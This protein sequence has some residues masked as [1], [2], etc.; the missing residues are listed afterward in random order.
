MREYIEETADSDTFQELVARKYYDGQL[1][2]ETAERLVGTE[3]AQ[4]LRL[5]KRDL[6]DEPLD[7]DAPNDEDIYD[8]AAVSVVP[9]EETAAGSD[10]E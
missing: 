4:R 2:F 10:E 3:T 9:D 6:D 8:G 1:D 5:L 7:L